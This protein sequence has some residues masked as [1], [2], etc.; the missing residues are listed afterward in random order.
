MKLTSTIEDLAAEA[1]KLGAT[2]FIAKF[3]N[4]EKVFNDLSNAIKKGKRLL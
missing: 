4:A 2:K 3:G 1:Q